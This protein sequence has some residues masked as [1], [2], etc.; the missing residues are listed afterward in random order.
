MIGPGVLLTLQSH[1][2]PGGAPRVSDFATMGER[3]SVMPW[4]LLAHAAATQTALRD[5]LLSRQYINWTAA[6]PFNTPW[7]LL[8]ALLM[9]HPHT[10]QS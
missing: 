7:I 5:T 6:A 3:S 2:L 1:G 9:L 10:L 4:S 8:C